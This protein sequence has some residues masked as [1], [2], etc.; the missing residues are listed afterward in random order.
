[1]SAEEIGFVVDIEATCWDTKEEQGSKPNEVIE[2]GVA[3]LEYATGKVID[4]ASLVV[5]PRFTQVSPF[6][7]ELTGWT[8]DQIMEQG[9][10]IAKVLKQFRETFKPTPQHTWF[11][12]GQYDKNMLSSKTQKGIGALYGIQADVNPFD[13][14]NHVN[15]KTEFAQMKGYKKEKGM[16]GMLEAI[17]EKLEGRHHNGADDA[18]NIAK[19][20]MYVLN[21]KGNL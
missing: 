6:C 11:S 7:T 12:C 13:F 1:M 15:I 20:V 8:Q 17:G 3:V 14:M 18:L 5:R 9:K 4:R 19:I 2:I 10:D 21:N 16:G